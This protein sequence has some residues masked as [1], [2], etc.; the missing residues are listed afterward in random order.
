MFQNGQ[1]H[2]ISVCCKIFEEFITI[3]NYALKG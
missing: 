3:M 1:A 2:F